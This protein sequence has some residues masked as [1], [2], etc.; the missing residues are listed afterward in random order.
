MRTP[1]RPRPNDVERWTRLAW[2]LR[3]LDLVVAWLCAWLALAIAFAGL[4]AGGLGTI[5][6]VLVGAAALVP[7]FRAGWRPASAAV[8]L[9]VSQPLRAGD[10]AWLVRPGEAELVLVT[11]RRGF[12]VVIASARRGPTEGIPVRR[13][14]ELLLPAD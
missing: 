13:T 10:R 2:W 4:P 12:S 14:R 7:S 3:G 5:A 6:A 8:G 9:S 1:I 11:A